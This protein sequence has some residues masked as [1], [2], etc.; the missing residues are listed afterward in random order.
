ME[1][2]Q[3]TAVHPSRGVKLCANCKHV[4]HQAC[5]HPSL[6]VSLASGGALVDLRE[7]RRSTLKGKPLPDDMVICGFEA[8]LF[9]PHPHLAKAL[10]V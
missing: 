8:K 5:N 6:P 4:Q 9:S 2:N 3:N 10:A 1:A 7:A